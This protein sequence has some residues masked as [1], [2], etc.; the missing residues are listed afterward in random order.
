MLTVFDVGADRRSL[1]VLGSLR[2]IGCAKV[3]RRD[4]APPLPR[5]GERAITPAPTVASPGAA[6]RLGPLGAT[7]HSLW[8]LRYEHPDGSPIGPIG[9]IGR[10]SL[11]PVYW[12]EW[13]GDTNG[14]AVWTAAWR[15]QRR[16]PP[17]E[18]SGGDRKRNPA[19]TREANICGGSIS[20]GCASRAWPSRVS[21]AERRSPINLSAC[22]PSPP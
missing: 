5:R 12:C 16:P 17:I 3:A 2:I 9:L 14:D 11:T 21:R 13:W 7:L 15:G 20:S 6:A 4:V 1:T 8:E 19:C 10:N 22:A 18:S